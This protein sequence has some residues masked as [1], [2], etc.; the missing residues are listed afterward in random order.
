MGYATKAM[1]SIKHLRSKIK[2]WFRRLALLREPPWRAL[3]LSR[4]RAFLRY[5]HFFTTHTGELL[6]CRYIEPADAEGLLELFEHLSTESRRRRFHINVDQ[7]PPDLRL[8]NARQLAGVDNRTVGGAVLA[9]HLLPSGHEEI[10]GVGRL[11]RS[12]H[13]TDSSEAEAAIVVRDDWQKR[14][15]GVELMRQMQGLARRMG[16]NTIVAS[17]DADNT[18]VLKLFRQLKFPVHMRTSHAETE[19]RLSVPD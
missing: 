16:V 18:P 5:T 17:V 4:P 11:G 10:I 15:V 9:V 13:Q 19:I 3:I 7:I 12:P 6:A 2:L 1:A 8:Q 14:G